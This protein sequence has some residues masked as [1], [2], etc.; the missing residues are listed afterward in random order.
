ME[1]TTR[2]EVPHDFNSSKLALSDVVFLGHQN[3]K[4]EAILSE[5]RGK[6]D[7]SGEKLD[8]RQFDSY[9][10]NSRPLLD[11]N[12]KKQGFSKG[13]IGE[14]ESLYYLP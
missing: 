14:E 10:R 12:L 3:S 11:M 6:S 1:E 4:E 8:Y 2:R 5:E 9:S 13:A 7:E